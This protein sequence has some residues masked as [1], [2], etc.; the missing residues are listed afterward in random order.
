[1]L[2]IVASRA[3]RARGVA[4][5]LLNSST[6]VTAPS[7]AET[8]TLRAFTTSALVGGLSTWVS[9]CILGGVVIIETENL[10]LRSKSYPSPELVICP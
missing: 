10:P 3:S 9:G 4:A 2:R 8:V 1:M 6:S 7:I 5:R